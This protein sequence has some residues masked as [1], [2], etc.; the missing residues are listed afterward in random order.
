M[1]PCSMVLCPEG[2]G[3]TALIDQRA[4]AAGKKHVVDGGLVTAVADL[5]HLRQA[6]QNLRDIESRPRIPDPED[7]TVHCFLHDRHVL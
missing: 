5:E 7:P 4:V 6:S 1:L 3:K 2:E